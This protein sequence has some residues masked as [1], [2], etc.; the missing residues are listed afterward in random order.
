VLTV[1][2]GSTVDRDAPSQTKPNQ[3][4]QAAKRV[5]P[6]PPQTKLQCGSNLQEIGRLFKAAHLRQA[7]RGP[8]ELSAG[9]PLAQ[10]S[11][12][13]ALLPESLLHMLESYG[14]GVFA[15]ALAGDHDTP[16]LVWTHAMRQGRLVPALLQHIGDFPHRLMQVGAAAQKRFCAPDCA[17]FAPLPC[18]R[19]RAAPHR[20]VAP[21]CQAC[22]LLARS[23][24]CRWR[25]N[26]PRRGIPPTALSLRSSEARRTHLNP[27]KPSLP[28][29]R[30]NT[31]TTTPHP[32]SQHHHAVYDYTP[33]PPL[34]WPELSAEIWCHRYYLRNLCDEDR[35][36]G[37]EVVE[38][39]PLLQVGARL[40]GSFL[41]FDRAV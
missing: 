28:A 6:R 30:L 34:A 32:P 26:A 17:P 41:P 33:I 5:A 4:N 24:P 25:T 18:R 31:K 7:F 19:R 21:A 2:L 1:H 27:L 35:F 16:E 3:T 10:R 38:H 11:Y 14:P 22:L 29:P 8:A 12:L 20:G 39:I 40:R 23:S 9:L 36:P 15:E 13:G 37:W